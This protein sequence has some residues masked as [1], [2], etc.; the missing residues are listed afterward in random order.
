MAS[1][2]ETLENKQ[3][4]LTVT[5]P[6]KDFD[7]AMQKAYFKIRKDIIVPGFRKGKVPRQVVQNHYGEEENGQRHEQAAVV[8]ALS[9]PAPLPPSWPRVASSPLS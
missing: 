5:V 3:V 9:C 7:D 6:Y 2:V 4:K 1:T 8:S